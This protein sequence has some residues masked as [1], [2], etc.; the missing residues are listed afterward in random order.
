MVPYSVKKNIEQCLSID[1]NTPILLSPYKKAVTTYNAN[2]MKRLSEEGEMTISAVVFYTYDKKKT[3]NNIA[4]SFETVSFRSKTNNKTRFL[5]SLS[6]SHVVCSEKMMVKNTRRKNQ[7]TK[8]RY[9]NALVSFFFV[10]I[11]PKKSQD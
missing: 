11:D 6:L 8:K 3:E 7:Q 1:Q 2:A 9:D 10:W 4:D 5:F